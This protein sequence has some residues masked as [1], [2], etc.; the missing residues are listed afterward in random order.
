MP[1]VYHRFVFSTVLDSSWRTNSS[2]IREQCCSSKEG[3]PKSYQSNSC[4]WKNCFKRGSSSRFSEG[5]LSRAYSLT[6]VLMRDYL[7]PARYWARSTFG[8]SSF[9]TARPND[10]H[11]ALAALEAAGKVAGIITQVCGQRSAPTWN[12]T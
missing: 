4:L 12:V 6:M 3:F 2:G 11:F 10:A 8:W 1:R 5:V 7:P 9:I